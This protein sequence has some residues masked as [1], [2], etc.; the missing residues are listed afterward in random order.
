MGDAGS[1][2]S[3]GGTGGDTSMG[4]TGGDT[5]MGGAGGDTSM[6][7]A[8]GDANMGGAGGD[9]SMGGTGGDTTTGG[10]GDT[11]MSGTGSDTSSGVPPGDVTTTPPS[12]SGTASLLP[13]PP[14]P[15]P[16]PAGT[17]QSNVT[18]WFGL[19]NAP[20]GYKNSQITARGLAGVT[21]LTTPPAAGMTTGVV[22]GQGGIFTRAAI[23]PGQMVGTTGADPCV[24]VIVIHRAAGVPTK[25]FVYHFQVGDKPAATLARDGALISGVQVVI[26][27]GSNGDP[28]S[29][30]LYKNVI[31]QCPVGSGINVKISPKCG[32]WVD[33][34]GNLFMFPSE[35]STPENPYP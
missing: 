10:T 28:S 25:F 3:M 32:L 1:D 35:A 15:P 14:T 12:T 31:D 29:N 13:R 9:T 27:G 19:S 2:A 17:I 22:R 8:G 26:F 7:G 23:A 30:G 4:G 34:D 11:S 18:T 20:I 24:G 5:N 33:R 16:P 6:G 21:T